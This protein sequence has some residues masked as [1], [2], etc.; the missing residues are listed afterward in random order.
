MKVVLDTN[1][2]VSGLLKPFG[3]PGEI[4]RMTSAGTLELCYDARIFSEY[5]EVLLRPE[6]SFDEDHV[7]ALLEQI[8]AAGHSVAGD[9]LKKRLPD[10]TDEA[11]LEA[12]LAGKAERL[13]TGNLKHFPADK[14]E[15]VKVVSPSEFL[16]FYRSAIS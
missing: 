7:D 1:V 3:T 4:V 14:R 12:A 16:E 13:I 6:F 11:F 9:P 10:P 15:G 5:R 2:L 8:K